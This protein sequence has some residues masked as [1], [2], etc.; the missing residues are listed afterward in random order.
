M[1]EYLKI[2]KDRVGALVGKKGKTKAMLQERC[3]VKLDITHDGS[4][5]IICPDEDGLKEWKAL[6]VVKAVGRGFSPQYAIRLLRDDQVLSIINLYTLLNRNKS[7]VTRVRARII[8]ENGK[9]RRTIESLTNTRISV[10]GKTISIIGNEEDVEL[11]EKAIQML[12]D[13]ARHA[14]VYRFLESRA[15]AKL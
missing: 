11:T 4:I 1:A 12:I 7:D 15:A 2:P 5:T 3:G 8:G 13:G 9:V 6:E 14:T 10:Y